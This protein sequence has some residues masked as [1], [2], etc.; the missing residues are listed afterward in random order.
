[1][2]PAQHDGMARDAAMAF[3]RC[4]TNGDDEVTKDELPA[5][6]PLRGHFDMLDSNKNGSLSPVEFEKWK[7]MK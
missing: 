1:M 3:E 5:D 2:D 6:P 4:D 7:T